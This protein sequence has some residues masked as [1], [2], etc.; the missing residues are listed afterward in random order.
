MYRYAHGTL[1]LDF[2]GYFRQATDLHPY[3]T[4]KSKLNRTS[5]ALGN[6]YRFSVKFTGVSV[7]NN[8]AYFSSTGA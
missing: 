6:S 4:R 1:P 8:Y 7:W 2:K 3:F 5:F